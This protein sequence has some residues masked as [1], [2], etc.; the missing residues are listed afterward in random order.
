MHVLAPGPPGEYVPAEHVV[1]EPE[2]VVETDPAGHEVQDDAPPVEYVPAEHEPQAET[3]CIVVATDENVP[4][5]QGMQLDPTL[6]EET[7]PWQLQEQSNL[8]EQ[9]LVE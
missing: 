4:A 5:G 3:D 2:P 1:Q 9:L 7:I 8:K 6:I